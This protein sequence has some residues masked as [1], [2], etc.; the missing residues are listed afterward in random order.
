MV[1]LMTEKGGGEAKRKAL[2]AEENAPRKRP[3]VASETLGD[4]TKASDASDHHKHPRDTRRHTEE[5]P[6]HHTATHRRRHTDGDA[7]TAQHTQ[8]TADRTG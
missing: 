8:G 5:T 7:P 1:S 6:R 3:T 4:T 2:Q